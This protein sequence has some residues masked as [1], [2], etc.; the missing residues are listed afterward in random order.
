[1]LHAFLMV[2]ACV[3]SFCQQPPAGGPWLAGFDQL[4]SEMDRHYSYFELK[5]IDWKGLREKYRPRAERATT[6]DELVAVLKEMLTECR[7]MHIW[8]D[9]PGGKRVGTFNLPWE[10]NWS[11]AGIRAHLAEV[12][13]VGRFAAV[14]KTKQGYGI[15]VIE[16]Q[17]AAT[18]DLVRQVNAKIQALAEVPGFIVDLRNA[19]GG[20][21]RLAQRFASQFCAKK[22]IYALSRYRNGPKH[23]DFGEPYG[24]EL[25]AGEKPFTKPVV[26][27]IGPRAMSSGEGLVKM[28][29]ALPQVTTVGSRTRGSSGN[30]KPFELKGTGIHVWFSRWVD[31]MPDGTPVEGRG[32]AP[33]IEATFPLSAFGAKD[34]V[35][36]KGLEVLKDKIAAT[37]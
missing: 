19:S 3:A 15:F 18:E 23:G 29:A 7:D 22:V 14:G 36:E 11:P 21:E 30:P 5:K 1:M 34:P 24:R 20:D 9:A 33:M 4:W 13:M 35:F 8:I 25:P 32:I 16:N 26:V 6:A 2:T 28:F 37:R 10:R 27:L 31:Q 12:A 17:S